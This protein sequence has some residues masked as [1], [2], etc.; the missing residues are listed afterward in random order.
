VLEDARGRRVLDLGAIG[1]VLVG[2]I[3]GF[4]VWAL[5][6]PDLDFSQPVG[7]VGPLASALLAGFG[8]GRVLSSLV[9]RALYGAALVGTGETLERTA[10]AALE[11]TTDRAKSREDDHGGGPGE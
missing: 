10:A 6:S 7:R 9:D 1:S 5:N 4:A 2:M 8:G 11:S 3:T